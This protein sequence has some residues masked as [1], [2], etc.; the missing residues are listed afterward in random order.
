VP[1]MAVLPGLDLMPVLEEA[2]RTRTRL[3]ITYRGK[4]REIDPYG[5]VGKNG[6]WYVPSMDSLR[7]KIIP[8]RI[9]RIAPGSLEVVEVDA[10]EPPE[11]LHLLSQVPGEAHVMGSEPQVEAVVVVDRRLLGVVAHEWP[12]IGALE[13]CGGGE[14]RIRVPVTYL[15]GFVS[16]V[17]AFGDR[18]VV[19]GPAEI[20]DEVVRR[21][22]ELAA[23]GGET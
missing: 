15:D 17:L 8:F 5:I 1:T 23:V 7:A 18:V 11:G 9:D 10:F 21:L 19:E 12:D 6:S 22:R 4:I 16:E 20:R 13:S 3:R 14:M 2:A